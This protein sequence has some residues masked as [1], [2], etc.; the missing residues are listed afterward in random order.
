MEDIIKK[1][2]ISSNL[3]FF[4]VMYIPIIANNMLF[5]ALKS[6]F[7]TSFIKII[8]SGTLIS[9]CCL[10]IFFRCKYIYV[11]YKSSNQLLDYYFVDNTKVYKS[12]FKEFKMSVI[13]TLLVIINII[14]IFLQKD[15]I[16][17][18]N[19]FFCFYLILSF[20]E[21]IKKE[22]RGFFEKK[23]TSLLMLIFEPL[24]SL[25]LF[26][27]IIGY[28]NEI[29]KK[30]TNPILSFLIVNFKIHNGNLVHSL[31]IL[32]TTVLFT[33]L[34]FF[35]FMIYI[36]IFQPPINL[37]SYINALNLLNAVVIFVNL[38]NMAVN[39]L[40]FNKIHIEGISINIATIS[41]PILTIIL[42]GKIVLEQ[43][44]RRREKVAKKIFIKI[45]NLFIDYHSLHNFQY[46]NIILDLKKCCLYGGD[47]YILLFYNNPK[48][49]TLIKSLEA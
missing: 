30:F 8:S 43:Q 22:S 16:H 5:N 29:I 6:G 27:Q 33:T 37:N 11:F 21:H 25:I 42:I 26:L 44:K 9:I 28:T 45:H 36:F 3:R 47:N 19:G 20:L 41:F 40:E 7:F 39:I 35:L 24:F 10:L 48:T 17:I 34:F 32:I 2:T 12:K 4:Y 23:I 49:V 14:I 18:I 1:L 46:N 13:T 31:E 15:E 38:A